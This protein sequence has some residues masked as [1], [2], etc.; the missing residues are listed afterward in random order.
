MVER[1]VKVSLPNLP[2]LVTIRDMSRLQHTIPVMN[3]YG[4]NVYIIFIPFSYDKIKLGFWTKVMSEQVIVH[5][6]L[7]QT[8]L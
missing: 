8:G 7:L 6:T 1:P 4:K 3:G 2:V 5:P